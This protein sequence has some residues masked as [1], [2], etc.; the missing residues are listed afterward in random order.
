VNI[1]KLFLEHNVLNETIE[2][3]FL[4]KAIMLAGGPGSGKSY[5]IK[6]IKQLGDIYPFPRVID[7]DVLFTKKL[8]VNKLPQ[9]LAEPNTELRMQQMNQRSDAINGLNKFLHQQLI[10]CVS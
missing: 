7:S 5:T 8:E 10:R 2:D 6:Q 9:K 1:L 3:K 4:L